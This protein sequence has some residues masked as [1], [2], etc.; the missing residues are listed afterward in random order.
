MVR[1]LSVGHLSV[2]DVEG[3]RHS[4]VVDPAWKG[5]GVKIRALDLRSAHKQLGVH[6]DDLPISVTSMH[7]SECSGVAYF[8]SLS[9]PFVAVIQFTP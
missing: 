9:L 8:V 5:V 1:A 2:V 7:W 3:V 4:C 6:G